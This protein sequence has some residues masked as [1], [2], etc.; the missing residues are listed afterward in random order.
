MKESLICLIL[1]CGPQQKNTQSEVTYAKI[2]N[3][4][5]SSN[6]NCIFFDS[7]EY[8]LD[9]IAGSDVVIV[10]ARSHGISNS[11]I[12]GCF[13]SLPIVSANVGAAK[14][15]CSKNNGILYD[16]GNI[17]ELSLTILKLASNKKLCICMGKEGRR[18]IESLFD[19][20]LYLKTYRRIY[21]I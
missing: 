3:K 13:C 12:E 19:I 5:K 16:S 8:P 2:K 14:E 6:I 11:L 4:I 1:I 20:R 15:I 7:I 18:L 21:S 10:P 9:I 17:K